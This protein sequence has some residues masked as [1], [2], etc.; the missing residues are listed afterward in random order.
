MKTT[1]TLTKAVLVGTL[2]FSGVA[3]AFESAAST[4]VR[5]TRESVSSTGAPAEG[6]VLPGVMAANGRYVVFTSTASNLT[7][8]SGAHVYR[9]DRAT[10]ATVLVTVAKS[11]APSAGGGFA[12]TVSADGRFVAFASAGSDF[13]DGDTNGAL[14]AFLRDM[15]SGTTAIVSASQTGE[16]GNLS[17][18]LNTAPGARGVSDDGRY[19]AFTSNA[20]NLVGTPNNGKQQ[21]YVKDML[22]GVVTRASVD[23]TGAAGNNNSS[24]PALS[25]NGHVVA[26]RSEAANF[27]TLSTSGTSQIFVRD[28]E[29]GTTTL[30]SVTTAGAVAPGKASTAPALSFDGRYVVFETM[31]QLDARDNDGA[32]TTDVYLRDRT[33]GTTV[34]ASLSANTAAGAHSQAASIS[35]D[36]RWVGFQSL[37]DK[38]V[39]G[40]TNGL[41]DVFVYD[42]TTEAITLVSLNDA[43][44]QANAHST[45]PSVSSDGQL[46]LFLSAA[47]NLVTSPSSSGSQL[48]A[49]D[50]RSNEAPV[51][52]LGADENLDEGVALSRVASFADED[53]STSWTATV[54]YGDGSGSAALALAADKSFTLEHLFVPG[55]YDVT[56]VVTDDAGASGSDSFHVTVTNVAPTVQLPSSVELTF[57]PTLRIGG[58]FSDPG[59]DGTFYATVDYGDGSG[60]RVLGLTDRSFTLDHVYNTAGTYSAVVTV[61]DGYGASGS[62][63]L[64]VTVRMYS[65]RWLEPVETSFTVGK[66][67]PVRFSVLRPDGSPVLDTSV[68]VDVLD[69]SGAVVAGYIYGAN[70]SGSV[71]WNGSE[72]HANVDTRGFAAGDYTL[73][74]SF[75]SPTLTGEFTKQT[76]AIGDAST[77][78]PK[79]GKPDKADK[80]GNAADKAGN[81]DGSNRP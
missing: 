17:S 70:P 64:E 48:Y 30:E 81:A 8:V 57:D 78:S 39:T 74:A 6:T 59:P 11:G 51:V 62:A 29:A 52:T 10:G 19:V 41:V 7:G 23:A 55:S 24:L 1:R 63:T 36:G 56:V 61:T 35:A 47:S 46:V 75:S 79:S 43:G 14:D 76:T 5:T 21:V 26:F 54:D 25:G 12:P 42:R 37:D 60:G 65:F 80:A 50:M 2:A 27:S 68:R 31:G 18:G 71:S 77:E 58:T 15:V 67:L 66:L 16:P 9:H 53:A 40:D 34:V 28:L 20:T 33:L 13:V 45:S 73:R 38:L 44:Q 32:F 3:G 4:L 72:Y 49:R 22:T 69:S